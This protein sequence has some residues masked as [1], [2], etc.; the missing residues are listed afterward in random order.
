LEIERRRFV[1]LLWRFGAFIPRPKIDSLNDKLE[2]YLLNQ[3]LIIGALFGF[4]QDLKTLAH[5]RCPT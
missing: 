2:A 1:I 3:D 5:V 4:I